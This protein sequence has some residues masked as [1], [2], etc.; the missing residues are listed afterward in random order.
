MVHSDRYLTLSSRTIKSI[1]GFNPKKSCIINFKTSV[2]N[3]VS[4]L[5]SLSLEL[6]N[7]SLL[8]FIK[9]HTQPVLAVVW[10]SGTVLRNKK[11]M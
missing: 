3:S 4:E 7:F 11:K 9:V 2:Y 6:L 5:Y 1:W 10:Y 8:Y